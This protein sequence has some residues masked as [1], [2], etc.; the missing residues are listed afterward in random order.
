MTATLEQSMDRLIATA[1]RVK[2]ERDALYDVLTD[3]AVYLDDHAD[4]LDG[5]EGEPIP[6]KAMQLL[7]E[8]EAVLAKVTQ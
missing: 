3:V 1:L 7:R 6:N 2:G 5:A 4:V 8:V